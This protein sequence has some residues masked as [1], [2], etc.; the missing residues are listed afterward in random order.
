[1][2]F[3]NVNIPMRVSLWYHDFKVYT[4]FSSIIEIFL[5]LSSEYQFCFSNKDTPM[6]ILTF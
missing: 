2:V 3:K 1:M 4:R 6:E 5:R